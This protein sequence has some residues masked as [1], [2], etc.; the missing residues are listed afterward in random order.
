MCGLSAAGCG[1]GSLTRDQTW[2]PAWGLQ[3]IVTGPLGKAHDC[4]RLCFHLLT[5]D[6]QVL[7][8]PA[9]LPQVEGSLLVLPACQIAAEVVAAASPRYGGSVV[10]SLPAMQRC[11]FSPWVRKI[12][13]EE[14]MATHSSILARR[15]PWMEEAGRLYSLWSRNE[16]DRTERLTRCTFALKGGCLSFLASVAPDWRWKLT[17]HGGSHPLKFP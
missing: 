6:A 1:S 15:I 9:P 11:G 16:S 8:S 7:P 2:A 13:V 17:E 14:G 5:Q 10:K 3:E 4:F 12:P